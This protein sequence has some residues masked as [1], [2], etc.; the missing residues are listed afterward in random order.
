MDASLQ[1]AQLIAAQLQEARLHDSHLQGANLMCAECQGG[2]LQNSDFQGA[3]MR[4]TRL[5]GAH[6]GGSQF[7]GGNLE[8]T[9]VAGEKLWFSVKSDWNVLDRVEFG[10]S[11]DNSPNVVEVLLPG[12]WIDSPTAWLPKQILQIKIEDA[13]AFR[14]GLKRELEHGISANTNQPDDDA[15]IELRRWSPWLQYLSPDSLGRLP[16]PPQLEPIVQKLVNPKAITKEWRGVMITLGI[17]ERMHFSSPQGAAWMTTETRDALLKSLEAE[18]YLTM[19]KESATAARL[20]EELRH[21]LTNEVNHPGK[22]S[23]QEAWEK[24]SGERN[25]WTL[26]KA[27]E[28]ALKAKMGNTPQSQSKTAPATAGN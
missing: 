14:D 15:M 12:A 16:W 3:D 17:D 1:G 26:R 11:L 20:I 18:P 9:R 23:N 24:A 7:P 6:L 27:H 10:T 28:A 5:Q 8:F 4:G 19:T 21:E 25:S 2:F 22:F 13:I